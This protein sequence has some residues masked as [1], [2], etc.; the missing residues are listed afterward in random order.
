[1]DDWC[2]VCGTRHDRPELCPGELSAHGPERHAW[3][4]NVETPGGLEAY[5]VLIARCDGGWRARILTFPNVLWL[6][7]GHQTTLKFV[8]ATPIEA[9]SVASEFIREHC[10][11]RGYVLREGPVL[12]QPG[13]IREESL[14]DADDG[15]APR[16]IRFLPVRFGV[17]RPSESGQTGNLS[18]SGLFVLTEIP[19]LV[20]KPLMLALETERQVV[21]L[22]GR[23]I[24]M[25]KQQQVGRDP[26]MGVQL[27]EPPQR[28]VEYVRLLR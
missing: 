27:I 26:G 4:V 9:E 20:G 12:A 11:T 14:D 2:Q 15:P 5:G 16:K 19:I 25:R 23:V 7:P 10:S 6:A 8:G 18:E 22:H 17:V 21:P 13:R 24:W 1:M 3:R 28:Y